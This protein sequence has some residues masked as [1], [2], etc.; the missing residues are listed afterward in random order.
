MLHKFVSNEK[1]VL[2]VIDPSD[3]EKDLNNTDIMSD[4]LPVERAL[5]I[6]W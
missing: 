4:K 6:H 2:A 1:D 5:G 3:R